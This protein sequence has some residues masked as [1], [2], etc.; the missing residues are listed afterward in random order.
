MVCLHLFITACIWQIKLVAQNQCLILVYRYIFK[1]NNIYLYVQVDKKMIGAWQRQCIYCIWWL[2]GLRM[3]IK[4]YILILI[5]KT[6]THVT[7]H[8]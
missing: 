2:S 8:I 3:L 7:L 1:K 5:Y 6:L 4:K